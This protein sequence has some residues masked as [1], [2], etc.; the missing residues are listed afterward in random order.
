MVC[1]TVAT[2]SAPEAGVGGTVATVFAET[3]AGSLDKERSAPS[4]GDCNTC[5]FAAVLQCKSKPAASSFR[6][7][8]R[9]IVSQA[10]ELRKPSALGQV[11]HASPA[12]KRRGMQLRKELVDRPSGNLDTWKNSFTCALVVR[13]ITLQMVY[14]R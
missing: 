6:S 8:L 3:P 1:A 14:S 7:A 9:N 10:A 5:V 4:S 12:Q 2:V 13:G 11:R